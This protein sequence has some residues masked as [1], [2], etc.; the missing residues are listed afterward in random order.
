MSFA[1]TRFKV[2]IFTGR[3]LLVNMGKTLTFLLSFHS[4]KKLHHFGEE[5]LHTSLCVFVCIF[6]YV[7]ILP[8][9]A[10]LFS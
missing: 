10:S 4:W 5:T 9:P 7:Q 8:I 2:Y 6:K 3:Y 1:S